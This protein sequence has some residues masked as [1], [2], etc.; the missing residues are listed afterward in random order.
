MDICQTKDLSKLLRSFSVW[1]YGENNVI[2]IIEVIRSRYSFDMA[3]KLSGL[4]GLSIACGR[5]EFTVAYCKMA[6]SNL[7]A[8]DKY[9]ETIGY[10]FASFSMK[11]FCVSCFVML[12]TLCAC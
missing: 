11:G 3:I 12:V 10:L 5:Y 8:T 2:C 4:I 9:S 1:Q 7:T 6:Q